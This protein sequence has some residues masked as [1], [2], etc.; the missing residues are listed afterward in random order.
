MKTNLQKIR[1]WA[2]ILIVGLVVGVGLQFAKAVWIEPSL[3]PPLQN[4][5]APIS[6]SI[7]DQTK[8]GGLSVSN[9][10]ITSVLGVTSGIT[11]TNG[12]NVNMNGGAILNASGITVNGTANVN[13][14]NVGSG[15]IK[16][17]DGSVQ[18]SAPAAIV[19]PCG[20]CWDVSIQY[21][22]GGG[23]FMCTPSGYTDLP[24]VASST[25]AP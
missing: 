7:V 6:S 10:I 4:V 17:S 22:G 20:P 5:E 8:S 19:C 14:M 15:G 13:N 21:M 1:Y 11:M 25:N 2:S 18:T 9:G 3:T 12:G 16:F 23:Y 24:F